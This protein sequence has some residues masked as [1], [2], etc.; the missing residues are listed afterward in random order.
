M[1]LKVERPLGTVKYY[2]DPALVA[3]GFMIRM[4]DIDGCRVIVRDMKSAPT[5]M[6]VCLGKFKIK[7]TV[8]YESMIVGTDLILFR[9]MMRLFQCTSCEFIWDKRVGFKM[10]DG[11]ALD[12]KCSVVDKPPFGDVINEA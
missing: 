6:R 2:Q 10:P 11:L 7:G 3:D 1:W 4:D 12:N 5:K 8:N 9:G